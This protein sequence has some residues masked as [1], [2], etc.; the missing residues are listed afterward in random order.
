MQFFFVL[1]L[2]Y[3]LKKITMFTVCAQNCL[4]SMFTVTVLLCKYL[5]K[6]S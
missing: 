2:F 3:M 6:L 1:K 5:K 4:A